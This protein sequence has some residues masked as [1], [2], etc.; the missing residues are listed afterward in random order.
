MSR[1]RQVFP[2]WS[3]S[4]FCRGILGVTFVNHPCR[5]LVY[6]VGTHSRWRKQMP[7]AAGLLATL[8]FCTIGYVYADY[9][10]V[11][12]GTWPESWPKDV[13]SWSFTGTNSDWKV[14]QSLRADTF[15]LVCPADV[16]SD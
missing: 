6:F 13:L 10:V 8:A 3:H 15:N 9:T 4:P 5:W 11:G 7:R 1:V 14:N 16:K 12:T 2:A